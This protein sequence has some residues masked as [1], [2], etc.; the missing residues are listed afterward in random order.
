MS[1]GM[2]K[3]LHEKGIATSR[4]TAYNPRGNGQIERFNG[5]LWRTLILAVKISMASLIGHWEACLLDALHSIRSLLCTA[6]N[7]TPHER[8]FTFNRKSTTG[9]SLPQWL[10]ARGPVL[11]RRNN[12]TSKY[13]PLVDEVE[14]LESNSKY[15]HVRLRDGREETVS[16]RH[17]APIGHESV[18]VS[19]NVE[20][21]NVNDICEISKT[22]IDTENDVIPPPKTPETFTQSFPEYISEPDALLLQQQR[23]RPYY[24]RNREA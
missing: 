12:R 4:T 11:M 16:I 21:L 15:A 9:T 2:K 22:Q 8:L 20:P 6:T 10:T 1:A 5:T 24:L 19:E 13:D 7:A 17:L 3:F 23:F 14:L 18:M